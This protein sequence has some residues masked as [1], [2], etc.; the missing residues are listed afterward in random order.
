MKA[1]NEQLVLDSA[2]GEA[3]ANLVGTEERDEFQVVN[4]VSSNGTSLELGVGRVR[5]LLTVTKR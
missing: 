1:D 2:M 5:V 4:V 3:R